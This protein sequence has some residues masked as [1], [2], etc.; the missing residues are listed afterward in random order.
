MSP[1]PGRWGSSV[2]LAQQV[3]ARWPLR[4]SPATS[5]TSTRTLGG[6]Q[7]RAAPSVPP[8]GPGPRCAHPRRPPSWPCAGTLFSSARA[9][10]RM[11][12]KQGSCCSRGI[13]LLCGH[14]VLTPQTSGAQAGSSPDQSSLDLPVGRCI[15][16][17]G[18]PGPNSRQVLPPQ[19]PAWTQQ[20][21]GASPPE[22]SPD[23]AAGRCFC[24]TPAHVLVPVLFRWMRPLDG[25]APGKRQESPGNTNK[26]KYSCP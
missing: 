7:S 18:Q 25:V 14:H 10:G 4:G 3:Q 19:R 20:Q 2:P 5:P 23:P 12:G 24:S 8:P 13:W 1:Q 17:G 15:P 26:R 16:P 21:A 11:K 22:A 6:P 9:Q